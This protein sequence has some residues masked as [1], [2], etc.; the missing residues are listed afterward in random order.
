VEP[1]AGY[2]GATTNPP[3]TLVAALAILFDSLRQ[4]DAEA[5]AYLAILCRNHGG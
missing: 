3:N 2:I 5:N 4:I 1:L